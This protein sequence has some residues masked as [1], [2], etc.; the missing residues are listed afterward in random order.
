[1][2]TAIATPVFADATVF[3]GAATSPSSRQARGFSVGVSLLVVGFEFE[4]ANIKEELDGSSPSVRTGMANAFLQTPFAIVGLQPYFTTGVGV[5]RERLGDLS[6]ET[7]LG[8]NTGGG[9]KISLLGPL[10]ARVDYRVFKLRD[11]PVDSVVHRIYVGANL[12]F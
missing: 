2:C 11:A 3:I 12:A 10:R 7:N 9:V 4:Y 6:Q 1:M 8:V 5:Y